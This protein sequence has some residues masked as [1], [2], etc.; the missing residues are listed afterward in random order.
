MLL[1]ATVRFGIVIPE[2]MQAFLSQL[3]GLWH[4]EKIKVPVIPIFS[5]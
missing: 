2:V 3:D 4:S 1:E 5:I